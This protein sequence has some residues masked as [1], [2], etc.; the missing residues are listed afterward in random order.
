MVAAPANAVREI[1]RCLK[2]GGELVGTTFLREGSRRSRALFARGAK[3]G[4]PEPPPYAELVAMFAE[5]GIEHVAIE[6]RSG[7]AAFRG[8]RAA[9]P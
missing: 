6:P 7:F 5:A 2:P 1:G 3:M 9:A 8:R 4:H